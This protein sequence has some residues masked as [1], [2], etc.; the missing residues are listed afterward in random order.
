MSQ[1]V[2]G[3]LFMQWLKDLPQLVIRSIGVQ[4]SK[5]NKDVE[6]E[7]KYL[8]SRRNEVIAELRKDYFATTNDGVLVVRPTAFPWIEDYIKVVEDILIYNPRGVDYVI[9]LADEL[10][11]L[12]NAQLLLSRSNHNKYA[13]GEWNDMIN[14]LLRLKGSVKIYHFTSAW[15]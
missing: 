9:P 14:R 10:L 4:E 3:K 12:C 1:G 11:E 7:I 6:N 8:I 15:R 5:M 13:E 2:R